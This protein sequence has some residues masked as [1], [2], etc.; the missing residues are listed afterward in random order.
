M[1]LDFFAADF[2]YKKAAISERELQHKMA[3]RIGV[4]PTACRLGGDR[5]ILLSYR[6][7]YK[8]YSIFRPSRKRTSCR[9]GDGCSILRAPGMGDNLVVKVHYGLGSRNR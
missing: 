8:N 5:S 4:E 9:L 6:D 1:V 7:I 2:G 3:S